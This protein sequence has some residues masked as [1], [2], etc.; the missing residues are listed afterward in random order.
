ME[1]TSCA[2]FVGSSGGVA[3]T[4]VANRKTKKDWGTILLQM[5]LDARQEGDLVTAELL[6]AHAMD[7]FDESDRLASRWRNSR[8]VLTTITR[9]GRGSRKPPA[10]PHS[11]DTIEGSSA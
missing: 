6:V 8:R 10:G 2:G 1:H 4:A 9:P 7:Y 3:E 11:D 5:A